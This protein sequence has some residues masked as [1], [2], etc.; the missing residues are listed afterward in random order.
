MKKNTNDHR[1]RVTRI[2]IRKAFTELLSQKPI[3]SIS[4]K[5]L[6]DL[7]GINRSTFY[8]HYEDIYD[9]QNQIENEMLEDFLKVLEPMLSTGSPDFNPVAISTEIFQCLKDNSDVCIMTLGDYGDK[10]FAEKLINIGREKCMASY[11][12]YFQGATAKQIEYF[13]AFACAGCIGLLRKW[14]A[15]GMQASAA[16]IAQTAENMMMKGIGFLQTSE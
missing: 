8:T 16:E 4:I 6:C 14:L 7:A 10:A 2:L 11:T 3:Q 12:Q 5:E 9:L 15:E 13:Y 1:T